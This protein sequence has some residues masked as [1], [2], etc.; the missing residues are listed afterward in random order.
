MKIRS[1]EKESKTVEE[2]IAE[3]LAELSAARD[4]VD[5]AVLD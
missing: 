4:A 5:V 2:A 3:G 1:I